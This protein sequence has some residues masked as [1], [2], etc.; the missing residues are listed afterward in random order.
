MQGI[1]VQAGTENV[2]I[3]NG[4]YIDRIDV[5]SIAGNYIGLAALAV[6][7]TVRRASSHSIRPGYWESVCG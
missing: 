7:L 1:A 4:R 6:D 2:Y 5:F 3:A